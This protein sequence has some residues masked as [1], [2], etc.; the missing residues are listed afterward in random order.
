MATYAGSCRCSLNKR[1]RFFW[2][3]EVPAPFL[4][5]RTSQ[6]RGLSSVLEAAQQR[7]LGE[8]FCVRHGRDGVPAS[9]SSEESV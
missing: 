7:R 1:M 3:L 5:T 4:R 8:S 6:R 2:K 9:G